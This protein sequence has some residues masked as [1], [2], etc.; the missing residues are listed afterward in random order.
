MAGTKK[1][2][3]DAKDKTGKLKPKYKDAPRYK[4][5]NGYEDEFKANFKTLSQQM[6][7]DVVKKIAELA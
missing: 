1:Q 5:T 6:A 3:K 7:K 4:A 2:H